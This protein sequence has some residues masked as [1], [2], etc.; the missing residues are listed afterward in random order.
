MKETRAEKLQRRLAEMTIYEAP[1]WE[2]GE[3][4][5]GI[6]EAGR[7][8]LAGPV[9][10][11][12]VIMPKDDLILGI[13]DSKKIAEKK[14][15]ALYD[16]IIEKAVDYAVCIIDER[17]IDDINILN[18]AG[19]AFIGALNGLKVNPHHVY[20]DAMELS[21]PL[22]C[23]SVIKGDAKIYTIAA[24]SIVAK[25]TRDRIML[26][27]DREYPEYGFARHK[28]YGT[29]LHYDALEKYGM[30]SIHRK[31][32]LKKFLEKQ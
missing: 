5:A 6:D 12:C 28:G 4:V 18:A 16:E 19:K 7:G 11:A 31:T 22:P 25:V 14:R 26:E 21:T 2:K 30:L 20:T 23:T 10:A 8:P 13:D 15:E 29:K 24:A 3:H 17:E 9:V 32:F 27:Y 1:H